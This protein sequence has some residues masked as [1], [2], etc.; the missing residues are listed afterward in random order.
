MKIKKIIS[1]PVIINTI[2]SAT[3]I[4]LSSIYCNALFDYLVREK[5]DEAFEN[6]QIIDKYSLVQFI[7]IIV[8]A[9]IA[10]AVNVRQY[11]K[12]REKLSE[13]EL[14]ASV[15]FNG[16]ISVIPFLLPIFLWYPY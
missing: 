11:R 3:I 8:L 9:I 10:F 6:R 12:S 5:L 7:S 16:L 15:W 4:V 2:V 13:K 1:L 14:F